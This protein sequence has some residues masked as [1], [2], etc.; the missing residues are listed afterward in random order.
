V[1]GLG[2]GR[3]S[4]FR[5]TSQPG[6]NDVALTLSGPDEMTGEVSIADTTL[7]PAA[8]FADYAAML[9]RSKPDTVDA[10]FADTAA[11]S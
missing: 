7:D 8:A 10:K 1:G 6:Q 4:A 3:R 2:I 5:W 11:R 9:H